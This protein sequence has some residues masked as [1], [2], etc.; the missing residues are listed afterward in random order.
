MKKQIK[1]TQDLP[2]ELEILNTEEQTKVKGGIRIGVDD[3]IAC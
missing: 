2:K 3:V 1:L